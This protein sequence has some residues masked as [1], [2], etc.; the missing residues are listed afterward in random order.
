MG[1][2]RKRAVSQ[3]SRHKAIDNRLREL[4]IETSQF[5]FYDHP[6]FMA[7]ESH[8]PQFLQQYADWVQSRPRALD[9]DQRVRSVVPQLAKILADTFEQEGMQRCCVH[10]SSMMPR[11]LDRLGVW[12]FGLK[13]SLIMEAP[14]EDL[15]RAQCI[16]DY[17]DFANAEV[18]H[19]WVVAPPF[20]IVDSTAHL[21]NPS[22]DPINDFIP[23]TIAVEDARK[24]SAKVDDIVSDRVR[25]RHAQQEGRW[26]SK[27]HERL[28]PGLREFN[29]S[30]PSHEVRYDNLTLRYVPVGVAISDV[31]LDQ[32]NTVGEGPSGEDVWNEHVVPALGNFIMKQE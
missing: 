6:N 31:P 16:C 20:L 11:I 21:Q 9:Y 12:S 8:D 32:I 19:A 27:L 5:G 18:G 1:E 17:Q 23:S 14:A 15:R 24:F 22:D 28:L 4:G 26:D 13:G 2:A 10:A 7:E 25:A 29:R 3:S 30:F